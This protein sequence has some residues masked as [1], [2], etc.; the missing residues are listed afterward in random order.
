MISAFYFKKALPSAGLFCFQSIAYLY[1]PIRVIFIIR[2][3]KN[4]LLLFAS[5]FFTFFS[6]PEVQS[7]T[8]TNLND[9]EIVFQN[10]NVIPMD[11][12]RVLTN[13]TVVV[14]NGKITA[15][16]SK[17]KHAGNAL[18]V[19][20]KGR[21]LM[22]GLA[23]MHAH[24]PPVDDLEPMK[25]VATL[26]LV[27][28]VTTIRGMLGHPRHLELREKL[29]TGEILGPHLYT[30]GPSFNGN[31]VKTPEQG[32]EKVRE[33]KMAGYD[34]LKLHPGLTLENFNAVSKAAKE[35]GIPFVGHVSFDVGVWRSIAAGYSS[36]DH[37]DGFIEGL[38]PG[39]ESMN[40]QQTGLFGLYVADKADKSRIPELMK[41]LK[42]KHVW[43]VPTQALAER[44]L[45]PIAPETLRD[46]P[47]MIYMDA[48]TRNSWFRT[49]TNLLANVT[50]QQ[51]DINEYLQL[52]RDLIKACQQSGV[53]LL[54][55]SDGPQVFNVPGFSVHHELRYL[56]N[57]GLT[58]YQAL[59]SGTVNVAEYLNQTA[60][61]GTL[62][63][64]KNADMVLLSG[65]PLQDITQTTQ[66]E[67]VLLR[68]RWL[69]KTYLESE[70][71]RLEKP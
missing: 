4:I 43:V 39:I 52:R 13:Q 20:G 69:D 51:T 41:A 23:E 17:A 61:S 32:A 62:A 36:I 1:Y 24:V 71:K 19:D 56:V 57:A 7:Q 42:D 11:R 50:Y 45:S 63:V 30:T 21:Y 49:K 3:M 47:E 48:K 22:P 64:G 5:L 33:Q 37:L 8:L 68:D 46:A 70:L 35:V 31:T 58:P 34:Y 28:G 65:N 2:P 10:V 9:R 6:Y 18:I 27:K 55:G 16:G 29:R 25:E 54:L 26:F 67:G 59:R 40:E 66:I 53:G 60:A 14:K 38:I 15:L 44:W 12:E